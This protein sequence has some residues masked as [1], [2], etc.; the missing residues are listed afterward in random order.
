MPWRETCALDE[1]VR[2][3]N[4]WLSGDETMT[5]LCARYSISRKTGYEL[6]HRYEASGAS[7]LV[8]RSHAPHHH[9]RAMAAMVREAIIELRAALPHWGPKKLRAR[10]AHLHPEV[11]WPA[12]S[13][14]GDLLHREGLVTPRRR[15]RAPLPGAP[16]AISAVS[17]ANDEWCV[18]FKGWFRT[19]DG[20]R[21][22]PLTLTDSYS[23]FLIDCRIVAPTAAGVGPV[24]ERAMRDLGLPRAI[25]SDNG[26]PFASTGAGGLTRLAVSWVK[27]GIRLH[28][29]DPGKP[30]QNGRHERMHK[31]LK[32]ETASPPAADPA[33]QQALF[34]I[35]RHEY[36]DVRPHE[37]LGQVPPT[38][39]YAP[40]PR[41]YPQRLEPITYPVDCAERRVRDCGDIRWYGDC[42]FISEALAG[43]TVGLSETSSGEWLVRFADLELGI[44][45][46]KTR[47][48]RRIVA[49]R[50]A[51][52]DASP[53]Q[54]GETVTHPSGL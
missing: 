13:T 12:A 38:R 2:F 19:G 20:V 44:I 45:E 21:C 27:L 3:I 32:G 25:R 47:K 53:E 11:A 17:G 34:D 22:D 31:T 29:I 14:I 5:M 8:P 50:S 10:L 26:P 23:R 1:K 35:W 6:V 9:G 16:Q 49:G 18:D 51:R 43:E 4:D 7:G 52:H 36:N 24:V 40:S 30:Q 39:H 33:V 37:A 41:P 54:T 28:R 42:V 15:R 46:R 48:L